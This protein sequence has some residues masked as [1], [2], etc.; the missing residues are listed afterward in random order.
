MI[1]SLVVIVTRLKHRNMLSPS[2]RTSGLIP[3][4]SLGGAITV[5][6]ARVYPLAKDRAK[7]EHALSLCLGLGGSPE[8]Q[9]PDRW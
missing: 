1:M 6:Y 7:P 5:W 8:L 3:L 4:G 2:V 9:A